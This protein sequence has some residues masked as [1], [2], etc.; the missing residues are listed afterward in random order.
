MTLY[1]YS[2]GQLMIVMM[3]AHGWAAAI[4]HCMSVANVVWNMHVP[5][6][7][8]IMLWSVYC[9]IWIFKLIT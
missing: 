7:W 8:T 4:I 1:Y 6:I 9:T 3:H 5:T 2:P